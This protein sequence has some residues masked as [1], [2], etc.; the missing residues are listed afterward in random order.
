MGLSADPA[1]PQR[2]S[3]SART[4]SRRTES[5][6]NPIAANVKF[7]D[8]CANAQPDL[9]Q[10]TAALTEKTRMCWP[11]RGGTKPCPSID[12]SYTYIP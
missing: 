2:I 4:D 6:R 3:G 11:G 8:C 10:W 7:G 9:S 5:A 12:P 1:R